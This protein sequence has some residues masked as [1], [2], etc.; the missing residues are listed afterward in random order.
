MKRVERFEGRAFTPVSSSSVAIFLA[1][2]NL[3]LERQSLSLP[4]TPSLAGFKLTAKTVFLPLAGDLP[5]KHTTASQFAPWGSA[6]SPS[7]TSA[8]AQNNTV[9]NESQ[10]LVML[11]E[12]FI[13]TNFNTRKTNGY[14]KLRK[15][16]E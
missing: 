12:S 8:L 16:E 11:S 9:R 3:H 13:S 2:N 6:L 1:I 15:F 7:V 5:L 4:A 10:P 14:V